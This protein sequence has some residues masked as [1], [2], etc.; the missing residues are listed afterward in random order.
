M[1]LIWIKG[2]DHPE[3]EALS[4]SIATGILGLFITLEG[5]SDGN[6]EEWEGNNSQSNKVIHMM[7]LRI[8]CAAVCIC[9]K[10]SS[11]FSDEF[12]VCLTRF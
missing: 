5:L 1:T 8:A 11:V 10:S 6:D 2:E 9:M 12:L 7:L 4:G 3:N